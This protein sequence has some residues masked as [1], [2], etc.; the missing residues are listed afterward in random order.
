VIHDADVDHHDF[1]VARQPDV[2]LESVDA[3][4]LRAFERGEGI[5]RPD[6]PAPRCAN[7]RGR[8]AARAR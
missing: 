4:R 2:E 1:P 8:P 6:P 5:F 7:T 3:E